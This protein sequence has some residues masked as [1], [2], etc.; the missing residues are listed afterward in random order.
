[1]RDIRKAG[2][3]FAAAALVLL[4]MAAL[5]VQRD[6]SREDPRDFLTASESFSE[7]FEDLRW[8]T[9]AR[10]IRRIP[11]LDYEQPDPDGYMIFKKRATRS[12]FVMDIVYLV[13]SH[14]GLV[15]GRYDVISLQPQVAMLAMEMMVERQNRTLVKRKVGRNSSVFENEEILVMLTPSSPNSFELI[16]TTQEHW[17]SK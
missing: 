4:V 12:D 16:V 6:V 10:I 11:D 1:M 9:P 2:F 3:M 8:G 15:A 7:G 14:K 5:A 17:H 13:D